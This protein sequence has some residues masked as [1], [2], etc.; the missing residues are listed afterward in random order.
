MKRIRNRRGERGAQIVELALVLPLLAFLVLAIA[1][2]GNFVR[3]HQVLNN[4][5]RE[6][7]R[8]S[9]L[10]ENYGKV[11]DIQQQVVAYASNNGVSLPPGNVTVNQNA[12]AVL[13]DGTVVSASIVTVTYSYSLQWVPNIPGFGMPKSVALS[14]A[15]E[16][17][18]LFNPN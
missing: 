10:Q 12:T 1:E 15:A 8:L 3:L 5:A 7:A 6:G 16:F 13:P 4:A 18:N 2:G 11:S 14:G 9:S 17:E